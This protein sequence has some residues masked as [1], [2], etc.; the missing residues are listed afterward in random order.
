VF[1]VVVAL[2]TGELID[3]PMMEAAPAGDAPASLRRL[4]R[5]DMSNVEL[6]CVSAYLSWMTEAWIA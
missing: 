4:F 5:A 2:T 1:V 3:I 6:V